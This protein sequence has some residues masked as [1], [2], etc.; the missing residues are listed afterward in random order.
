[1]WANAPPILV[2]DNKKYEIKRIL[3]RR[4]LRGKT[5]YLVQWR[6]YDQSEDM[7][8]DE[9]ELTNAFD[10][11]QSYRAQARLSATVVRAVVK[12]T[13]C[14][15]VHKDRSKWATFNHS[16][17]VCMYCGYTFRLTQ[18]CIGVDSL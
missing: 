11:L 12:C 2:D 5:K 15:K 6:G 9:S 13:R 3:Q 10:V 7:W 18:P 17:Q 8:L 14:G 16:K 4:Q 1:M